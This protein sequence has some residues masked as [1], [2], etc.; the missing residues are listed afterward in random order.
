MFGT[1]MCADSLG[2]FSYWRVDYFSG[3]GTNSWEDGM[4]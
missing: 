4:Y 1:L 3:P 2:I